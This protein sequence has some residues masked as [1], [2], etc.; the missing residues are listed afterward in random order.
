MKNVSDKRCTEHQSTHFVFSDFFFYFLRF[1]RYCGKNIVERCRL[2]M[3]KW[4]MRIA[5]WIHNATDTHSENVMTYRFCTT[6]LA[7]RA[8]P[9]VRTLPDFFINPFASHF[10]HLNLILFSFFSQ[11][12]VVTL[13]KHVDLGAL[14]SVQCAVC[15]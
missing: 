6:T 12:S 10:L 2:Q 9:N 13:D 15:S 1:L 4:R 8:R 5:C 11:F 14:S 3:A 7:A